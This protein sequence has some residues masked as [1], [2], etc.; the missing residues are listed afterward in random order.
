M[1]MVIA[2]H[3]A[4]APEERSLGIHDGIPYWSRIIA[5]LFDEREHR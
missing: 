2:H 5:F 3:K 1:A 4:K